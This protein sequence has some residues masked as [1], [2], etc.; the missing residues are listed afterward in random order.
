MTSEFALTVLLFAVAMISFAV[1]AWI[2]Y[3]LI[4]R[5]KDSHLSEKAG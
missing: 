4:D 1:S 3:D 5:D 2:I